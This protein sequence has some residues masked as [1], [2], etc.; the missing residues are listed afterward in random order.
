M[1]PSVALRRGGKLYC[2]SRPPSILVL[3]GGTVTFEPVTIGAYSCGQKSPLLV[4]AGPCVIEDADATLDL[5]EKL[6]AIHERLE[7]NLVFKASFDKANRT[8][9]DAFRGVGLERGLQI[10]ERVTERT[11]LPVTTDIHE[12]AQAAPAGQVCTLLQIPAFLCRQTDL[13]LA[14]ARTGCAVNAK[15]GQ[16]L[17]PEDMQYVIDKLRGGGCKDILVSERG[18]FFG[19]GRLASDSKSIVGLGNLGVPVIFD[20]THSVQQPGSL[21]G[22]TGGAREL[23]EPLARAAIALGVDG[24]FFE[25]HPDPDKSP[26]D[27]QNMIPL[28][29]FEGVLRR[30]LRLRET[31]LETL[32]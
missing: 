30:L 1:R 26:S 19:Y 14:A 3:S 11:G 5:A 9:L 32:P 4:I 22:A 16:F 31:A 7:I 28:D 27:G 21:P 23:V 29:T 8:S 24:L 10:L 13:L 25:T 17:A 6:A 15:K 20:A 18:T 12:P 2:P